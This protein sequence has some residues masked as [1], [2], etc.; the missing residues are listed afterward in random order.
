MLSL[1]SIGSALILLMGSNAFVDT[2]F[3][4]ER[5]NF[6]VRLIPYAFKGLQVMLMLVVVLYFAGQKSVRDRIEPLFLIL[7]LLLGD[8]MASVLYAQGIVNPTD[9]ARLIFWLL[10]ALA[11][12]FLRQNGCL[13]EKVLWGAVVFSLVCLRILSYKLLGL[14]IG[15]EVN[16]DE[17][18]GFDEDGVVNNLGYSLVWLVPLFLSFESKFRLPVLL[19]VFFSMLASFKRGALVG[20]ILGF[21][22]YYFADWRVR[23]KG[24]KRLALDLACAMLVVALAGAGF[25][26]FQDHILE[27]MS[28][29]DGDKALGS[30]REIFYQIV[31]H[32]WLDFGGPRK[33]IGA[34]FYQVMPMLGLYYENA[35]PAHSDWL[36]T[37]YDQGIIGTLIL[38]AA[39]VALV[40]RVRSA[41]RRRLPLA[42]S[43]AYSY[44]IFLLAS[45]Y[46]ITLYNFDTLWFGISLGY[47]L[48][49]PGLLKEAPAPGAERGFGAAIAIPSVAP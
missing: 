4:F 2:F 18:G 44:V 1:R 24:P 5:G 17:T 7:F 48:G 46:S 38:C 9:L 8:V 34:G 28:D 19:V 42:P 11:V 47:Y 21:L 37:L 20:L 10:A 45:V 40:T 22:A 32:H 16:P 3:T 31:L 23:G 43:L 14:W 25:L 29:V 6:T 39:H 36:E 15:A 35:I 33:I 41:L 26:L 12:Y 30:G 13:D 27:R 49:T